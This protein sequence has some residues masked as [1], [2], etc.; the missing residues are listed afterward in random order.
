MKKWMTFMGAGALAFTLSGCGETAQPADDSEK[1]NASDTSGLTL[2]EVFSRSA[3]ATDEV[4]SLHADVLTDQ[5]M[6]MGEEGMEMEM[7]VDLGMDMTR[8]PLAFY[9]T[10]ETSIVSEDIQNENPMATEMYYTEAGLFTYEPTMDMW[11]KMPEDSLVGMEDL[12]SQDSVD[13][14]EQ[15]EQLQAFQDDFVFEQSADEYILKLDATGEE[16]KA[17]LDEQMEGTLGKMEIEAQRFLEDMTIQSAS[18]E[19]FIDKETFLTNSMNIKMDMDLNIE[20]DTMNIVS[21][22]QTTYSQYDEIDA[23]TVPDEVLEQTEENS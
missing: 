6:A 18:Y 17:L 3:E 12:I 14:S 5:L 13:P 10:A 4:S 16:F 11:I 15:L 21:D 20:G 23:I 2:E 8:E 22:I 19:V 7:T 9:Q 1:E